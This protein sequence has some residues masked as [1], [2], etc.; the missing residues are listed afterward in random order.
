MVVNIGSMVIVTPM[1]TASPGTYGI[2]SLC[3]AAN[4][5]LQYADIG[6]VGAAFKYASESYAKK[7]MPEEI[8]T[9]GFASFILLVFVAFYSIALFACSRN[10]SLLIKNLHDPNEFRIASQ[11]LLILAIFSPITV[12]QRFLQ[13]VFG[14]RVEDYIFQ[15]MSLVTSIAKILSVFYFFSPGKYDIVGYFLFSQLVSL[16]LLVT[17]VVIARFRYAYDF[18]LFFRSIRFSKKMFSRMKALAFGSL[19][20]TLVWVAFY[21]LDLFAIG[22]MIGPKMAGIYAV[23]FTLLGFYRGIFGTIYSPFSARFNHFR[24]QEREGGLKEFFLRVIIITIPLVTFPLLG[25]AALLKP[26]ILSWVG[27]E[28]T[29]SIPITLLLLLSFLYSFIS[30]PAGILMTAQVRVKELNVIFT[31][32]GLVTWTGIFLTY[33]HL[34]ALAFALFKF[35]GF[36]IF[37]IFYA[38][39][40]VH[41]LGLGW[42]GFAKKVLAPLLVPVL[43]EVALLHWIGGML[44]TEKGKLH[45]L[46]T[47]SFGGIGSAIAVALYYLFSKPFQEYISMVFKKFAPLSRNKSV[48]IQPDQTG[49]S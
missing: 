23:G 44:P 8:R 21:E 1:I 41:Y 6:F 26:F 28:Y 18:P 49:F 13:L 39:V 2:Y 30:Y 47:V 5:F 20:T 10:P 32:V 22:K 7:D 19:Y 31:L 29:T 42:L 9:I 37:G 38:R 45:L 36:S 17:S 46:L 12:L 14:V 33:S 4:I 34:H 25:L 27:P 11:L 43:V 15:R 35:V 3:I 16:A 24:G 40:T 48:E